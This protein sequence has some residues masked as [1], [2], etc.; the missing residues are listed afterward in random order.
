MLLK[1]ILGLCAFGQVIVACVLLDRSNVLA[2]S[3]YVHASIAELM[4]GIFCL[5][6]SAV[7]IYSI[8]YTGN[9]GGSQASRLVRLWLDAKEADLKKRISGD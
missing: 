8:Q 2:T 4:S 7:L 6:T 9:K 3:Y 5:I 1:L